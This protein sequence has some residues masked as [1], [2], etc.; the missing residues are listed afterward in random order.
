M[1]VVGRSAVSGST[2]WVFGSAILLACIVG[3]LLKIR[4][5]IGA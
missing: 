2:V 5:E 4:K 3:N 1:R